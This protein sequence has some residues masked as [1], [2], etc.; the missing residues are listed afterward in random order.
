[1]RSFKEIKKH[2]DF[3]EEDESRLRSLIG[4]MTENVDEVMRTL[5]SWILGTKETARFFAD[6]VRKTRVFGGHRVWFL[7]LFSGTYDHRYYERLI[8]IGQVHVKADVEAHYMNRAVNI[9][10]GACI[11]ILNRGYDDIEERTRLLVSVEKIL[12]I[13]LDV[14]TSSYIEEELRTY[15]KAYRLKNALVTFSEGFAQTMNLVLILSLI[16][17]TL[18]VVG[19]FAFDVHK[20][21]TGNL[22]HGIITALGSMLILWVMIELMNTEIAHLK[23]GKFH[24]SVF[25]GVALVAF[26]R[27]TLILTLKNETPETHYYYI[28][29]ILVLGIVFWLVTK[30]EERNR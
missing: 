29:L 2:Y 14:I 1:M 17:L 13:S 24:I 3:T 11:D 19:L 6:E 25:I 26:I 22:E 15:S 16:G 20:L 5:S 18:G 7:D 4:V 21:I 9:I 10:R 27:E 28:A 23:G 12:D 8:R 30:A